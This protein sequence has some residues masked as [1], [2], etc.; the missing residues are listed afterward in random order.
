MTTATATLTA[1]LLMRRGLRK[2]LER[3]QFKGAKIAWLESKGL[4]DSIFIIKGEEAVV[5]EIYET[6]ESH[7]TE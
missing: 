7:F 4:I 6:L 5:R 2:Y 1:G 3:E